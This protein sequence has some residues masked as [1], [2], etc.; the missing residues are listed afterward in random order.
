LTCAPSLDRVR[1][2]QA[3]ATS[4][5]YLKSVLG[6]CDGAAAEGHCY[7]TAGT[8]KKDVNGTWK[9][10][11]TLFVGSFRTLRKFDPTLTYLHIWN[12]PNAHFWKDGKDGSHYADF[13]LHIATSLKAAFP[14]VK[15][16]G[17]TTPPLLSPT[18]RLSLACCIGR[19]GELLSPVSSEARRGCRGFGCQELDAMV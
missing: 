13:F 19:T 3:G 4:W 14:D 10:W 8:P 7:P 11:E 15:I 1:V 6:S 16:G 12:E 5:T 9:W 17:N 18:S 2:V